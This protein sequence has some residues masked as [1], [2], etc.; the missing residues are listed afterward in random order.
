MA[1]LWRLEECAWCKT[2]TWC[3]A[4]A[5]GRPQCRACEV[6]R[7][8]DHYLYPPLGYRLL[9]WQREFLRTI[10]GTSDAETHR[11][12]YWSAYLCVPKKQGK[13]FLVAGLPLYHLIVEAERDEIFSPLAVSAASARDQAS[14]VMKAALEMIQV[15]PGLKARLKPLVSKKTILKRNGNGEYQV[16]SADGKTNDGCEPSLVIKDEYHRWGKQSH[17]TLD[18]VL[19]KGMK[20]SRKEPLEI[21]ITTA[22][23]IYESKLW[24]AEHQQ[25]KNVIAGR[26]TIARYYAKIYQADPERIKK[27]PDYWKSKEARVLACPS[28]EVHGG[29]ISDEGLASEVAEAEGNPHKI[30]EVIRLILNVETLTA[31]VK[32][33]DPHRWAACGQRKSIVGRRC[34]GGVDLASTTDLASFALWF[35]DDS[36]GGG[37]FISWSW[38]PES[39]IAELSDVC[40]VALRKWVQDGWLIACPGN[41]IDQDAIQNKIR[42]AMEEFD[43]RQIGY[44]QHNAW[45]FA[46]ELQREGVDMVPVT[47]DYAGLNEPCKVIF[48]MVQNGELRHDHQ[49][50]QD[51]AADC[52]RVK[53]INDRISPVK[54]DRAG[55]MYRIDPMLALADAMHCYLKTEAVGEGPEC[56]AYDHW[57]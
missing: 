6:E 13:T 38:L 25:A 27:E 1:N 45:K 54:P 19:T 29:F 22:G 11:R 34:Y 48:E 20:I 31:G 43:V 9:P 50:L 15:N 49:P 40:K 3:L 41:T 14:L 30:N 7:F 36:G 53:T 39:R 46:S 12:Y 18:S 21:K 47:Q 37:D 5:D 56:S 57:K 8:F 28:H 44:D 23:S 10:Y 17:E 4:R 26:I 42:W 52:L 2:P 51:W 24:A 33:I 16:L 55:A 32:A 35:P